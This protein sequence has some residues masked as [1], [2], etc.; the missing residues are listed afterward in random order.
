MNTA[1]IALQ[2]RMVVLMAILLC[3]ILGTTAPFTASA[4]ALPA[5]GQQ[6]LAPSAVSLPFTIMLAEKTAVTME[7]S[8]QADSNFLAQAAHLLLQQLYPQQV[9]CRALPLA[10]SAVALATSSHPI[11]TQG[12]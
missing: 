12:P 8:R 4:A 1:G 3:G 6:E 7:E 2:K 5:S 9:A 11:R 10:Y